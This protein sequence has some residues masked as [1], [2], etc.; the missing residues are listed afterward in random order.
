MPKAKAK[1][2]DLEQLRE[3]AKTV[4]QIETLHPEQEQALPPI[5]E[6][7]DV[8]VVLPT[9]AGKSLLYQL[10]ALVA[11]KPTVCVSPLLSLMRD[12]E[13]KLVKANAPVVRV[14]STLKAAER[15][16][17]YARIVEGGALVILTTPETLQNAEFRQVLK[18]IAPP[19][20]KT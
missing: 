10:P 6:G 11:D 3:L 17:A 2:V 14:D 4:F 5:A 19:V 20:K 13:M 7:K 18:G 12:Q 9:G 1:T 16:A 8:L 15:R